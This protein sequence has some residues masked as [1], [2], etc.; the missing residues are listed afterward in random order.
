MIPGSYGG[1]DIDAPDYASSKSGNYQMDQKTGMYRPNPGA[2][3]KYANVPGQLNDMVRALMTG[4][5]R[6]GG[7]PY[8]MTSEAPLNI[9]QSFKAFDP[10]ATY[11][12]P[13]TG[14]KYG[15]GGGTP[16]NPYKAIFSSTGNDVGY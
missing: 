6:K 11:G 7:G 12:V 16:G 2:K 13:Y 1:Q 15:D 14:L 3:P 4:Y 10:Y 9:G 8:G 5:L